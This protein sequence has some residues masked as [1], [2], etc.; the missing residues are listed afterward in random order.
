MDAE[1]GNG[2]ISF[3]GRRLEK[4]LGKANRS[5]GKIKNRI[6]SFLV[7]FLKVDREKVLDKL[8]FED[9]GMTTIRDVKNCIYI[10][11]YK[12]EIYIYIFAR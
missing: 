6:L 11:F 10:L 7:N 3:E 9:S 8:I 12:K 2:N 5:S 4:Y 1:P